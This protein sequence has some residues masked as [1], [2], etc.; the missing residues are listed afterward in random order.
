MI[1]KDI[2]GIKHRAKLLNNKNDPYLKYKYKY[3]Y[4]VIT[5][6]YN[7]NYGDDR[8]C[9]CGHSYDS[10]FDSWEDMAACYCKYCNC[11][12][13]VEAK[14]INKRENNL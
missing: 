10:H 5:E 3:E 14:I 8:I 4:K 11:N 12:R 9:K 13:F 6:L 7:P 1:I 2:F